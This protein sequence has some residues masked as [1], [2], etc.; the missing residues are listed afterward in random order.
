MATSLRDLLAEL[1]HTLRAGIVD[2]LSADDAVIALGHLGR[3]IARLADD[4]LGHDA[5]PAQ[6]MAVAELG[7]A[8]R[9]SAKAWTG[10]TSA[11]LTDLAGAAADV[12]DRL[13]TEF[14]GNERWAAAIELSVTARRCASFAEG[15]TPYTGVPPL[16][17]TRRLAVAVE[18]L[19][20]AHPPAAHR[21]AALDRL[22]PVA[23]LP[24]GLPGSRIAAE[25]AAVVADQLRRSVDDPTRAP[26]R[27]VEALAVLL[28][29]ESTAQ[30]ATEVAEAL[31]ANALG[32]NEAQT[33]AAWRAARRALDRFDD[34]TRHHPG[35]VSPLILWAVRQH[36][37]LRHDLG[38]KAGR[39]IDDMRGQADLGRMLTDVRLAVNQ[40][41]SL[42]ASL[43]RGLGQWVRS[44]ALTA[45][46]T[47]LEIRD[48]RLPAILAGRAITVQGVDLT[49]VLDSLRSARLLSTGLAARLDTLASEAAEHP[50]PHLAASYRAMITAPQIARDL[51]SRARLLRLTDPLTPRPR[52]ATP[53]PG[54]PQ[55]GP[56]P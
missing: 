23:G 2:Q 24:A 41:P 47:D 19:G 31:D 53:A 28:A 36:E 56:C 50:Q 1:D 5:K 11:R 14:G 6:T 7:S 49:D 52:P 8:C 35:H 37:G 42:A 16:A 21:Q 27:L 9:A 40:L 55:R 48:D 12:L 32:R 3:A 15:H 25:S 30:Y 46:A 34:G 44:G 45:R 18:Q 43:Q 38:R 54:K 20:A 29:A 22:V 17:R 10:L 39:A 4:G 13:R 26:V 33:A 51:A